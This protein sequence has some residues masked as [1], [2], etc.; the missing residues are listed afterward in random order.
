METVVKCAV[1]S[2]I[3]SVVQR[4]L[5]VVSETVSQTIPNADPNAFRMFNRSPLCSMHSLDAKQM[6]R[7][8]EQLNS[9]AVPRLVEQQYS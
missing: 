1:E 8:V 9:C 2:I 7:C 3:E 5:S 6:C 4:V